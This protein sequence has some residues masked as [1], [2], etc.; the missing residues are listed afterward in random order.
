MA[1]G[2]WMP[3]PNGV[4][5]ASIAFGIVAA[6]FIILREKSSK[7]ISLLQEHNFQEQKIAAI[8][9]GRTIGFPDGYENFF[10][11]RRMEIASGLA[12][13]HTE[14]LIG[15]CLCRHATQAKSK[16][17]FF[18]ERENDTS[19]L[20][21]LEFTN[22][23]GLLAKAK[24]DPESA[25]FIYGNRVYYQFDKAPIDELIR[26]EFNVVAFKKEVELGDAERKKISCASEFIQKI[27]NYNEYFDNWS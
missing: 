16:F 9:L 24:I 18:I 27:G 19:V 1:I 14:G 5:A 4:L 25:I 6:I 23:K 7:S 3:I 2:L 11:K 10:P 20:P 13:A 15:I 22:S 21:I 17:Y 26:S 12:Q 8:D